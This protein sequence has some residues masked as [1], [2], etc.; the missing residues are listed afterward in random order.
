[1]NYL[2]ISVPRTGR[3]TLFG[4]L[5]RK[6]GE[7]TWVWIGEPGMGIAINY[8]VATY[9]NARQKLYQVVNAS[10]MLCG[11]WLLIISDDAVSVMLAED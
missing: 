7:T 6:F 10:G 2:A 5:R 4:D 3:T 11:L 1:M 9:V 8:C